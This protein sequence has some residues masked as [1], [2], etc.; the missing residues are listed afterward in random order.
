MALTFEWDEVK[1]AANVRKHRVS[2]DEAKTVFGDPL[3]LTN[4]DPDHSTDEERFVD[5]GMS[6]QG[7]VLVVVY[8]ER[9]QTIRLVS[10]RLATRRERRIYEQNE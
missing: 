7:R 1:A 3:S 5:I 2:F 10:C 8:T 4:A 9:E 6:T